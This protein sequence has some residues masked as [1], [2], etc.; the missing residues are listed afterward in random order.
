MGIDKATIEKIEE[1]ALASAG[2]CNINGR[3]FTPA[4]MMQIQEPRANVMHV[5][6]LQALVDYFNLNDR[7]KKEDVFIHVV[8]PVTVRMMS[9]LHEVERDR[10]LYIQVDADT[11][12]FSY[13]NEYSVER[14]IV[15]LQAGFVPNETRAAILELVGNIVQSA[16]V[17]TQD[18]G[19]TQVVTA[20]QGI[21]DPTWKPVPNPVNLAPWRT[22]AE[23]EQPESNFI[24]RVNSKARDGFPTVSLHEVE[25]PQWKLI[26]IKRIAAWLQKN[27]AVPII[28]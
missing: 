3:V 16:T 11:T 24:L 17:K 10:E 2:T 22:F 15:A 4:R 27:L 26:A 21:D 20:K 5:A 12:H 14:F 28:A 9:K 13:G 6:T 19:V 1:L 23:V 25:D 8:D 7:I 18:D